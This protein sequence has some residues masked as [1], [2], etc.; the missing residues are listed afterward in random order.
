MDIFEWNENIPVTANNLNEMQNILNNNVVEGFE[1]K[2]KIAWTNS[3]QAQ[4]ISSAKRITLNTS[5]YDMYEIFYRYSTNSA[6]LGVKSTGKVLK[7]KNTRIQFTYYN[8]TS[9]GIRDRD[10]LY[11]NDTTYEIG[12]PIG[13]DTSAT[14]C[15]P[16]YVVVYKTGL[17]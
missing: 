9:V 14:S 15:I 10:F 6:D 4:A 7:G 5:D 8:G 2:G 11:I 12:A 17:F 16:L 1:N 3:N 13:S